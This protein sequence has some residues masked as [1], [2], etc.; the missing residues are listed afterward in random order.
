MTETNSRNKKKKKFPEL[1]DTSCS[2][3]CIGNRFISTWPYKI[4]ENI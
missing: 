1:N 2:E 4:S 3:H